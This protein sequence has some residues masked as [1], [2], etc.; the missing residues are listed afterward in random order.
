MSTHTI[1]RVT[2]A[3][4]VYIVAEDALRKHPQGW[5]SSPPPET[6]DGQEYMRLVDVAHD[7]AAALWMATDVEYSEDGFRDRV[8]NWRFWKVMARK[9]CWYQ[10]FGTTFKAAWTMRQ[11]QKAEDRLVEACGLTSIYRSPCSYIEEKFPNLKHEG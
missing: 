11:L 5:L 2:E 9:C 4:R 8:W 3:L 7:A 6:P 10:R 1:A